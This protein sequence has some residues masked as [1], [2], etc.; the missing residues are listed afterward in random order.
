[1]T[2]SLRSALPVALWCVIISQVLLLPQALGEGRPQ[3]HD[4]ATCPSWKIPDEVNG[5]TSGPLSPIT[6]VLIYPSRPSAAAR[7]FQGLAKREAFRVGATDPELQAF[8]SEVNGLIDKFNSGWRP[9]ASEIVAYKEK[10]DALFKRIKAPDT[11]GDSDM[12]TVNELFLADAQNVLRH[13]GYVFDKEREAAAKAAGEVKPTFLLLHW[14]VPVCS[15]LKEALTLE[16]AAGLAKSFPTAATVADI[17]DKIRDAV[18]NGRCISFDENRCFVLDGYI[19]VGIVPSGAK[20]R[21]ARTDET[22][23]Y[24]ASVGYLLDPHALGPAPSGCN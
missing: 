9:S 23:F 13:M 22:F 1:M 5:I 17:R 7:E 6:C 18:E 20:L 11:I 2:R 12:R 3:G 24:S 21:D 15:E 10:G 19:S 8:V 16:A 14:G 4:P